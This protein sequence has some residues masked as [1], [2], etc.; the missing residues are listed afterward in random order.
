MMS[1]IEGFILV[2]GASRRMGEPKYKLEIGGMTFL[3]RAASALTAMTTG[4]IIVVGDIDDS[5]L[6]VKLFD[7]EGRELR[8]IPDIISSECGGDHTG[9]GALIGLFTALT[10]AKTRWIAVLA[11]DLPFVTGDLMTRIANCRSK[12]LEAIVPIQ[13]DSRVQPL[14]AV[15][16]REGCLPIV[17]KMITDGDLKMQRLISLVRTRFVKFD[18]IADLDG[19]SN[20]FLNVNRPDDYKAALKILPD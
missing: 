14:C 10:Y 8:K 6:K 15:Y 7:G 3:E 12:D 11:C 9:C 13:P 4:Q 16:Q 5:Y 2:G 20:F 18:E 17:E 19:S 1:Q